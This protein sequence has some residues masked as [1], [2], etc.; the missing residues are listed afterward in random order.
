MRNLNDRH[1]SIAVIEIK[2]K[3]IILETENSPEFV[4]T[5]DWLNADSRRCNMLQHRLLQPFYFNIIG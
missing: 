3:C 1:C 2:G 4:N 5:F